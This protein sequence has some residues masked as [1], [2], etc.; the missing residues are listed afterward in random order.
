MISYYLSVIEKQDEIIIMQSSAIDELCKLLA[1]HITVEEF[2]NLEIMREV[3]RTAAL[4][5]ALERM[6]S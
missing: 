6:G 2:E 5:K 4:K 3:N 1:Q